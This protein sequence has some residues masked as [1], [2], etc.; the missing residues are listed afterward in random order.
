MSFTKARVEASRTCGSS[1]A[2]RSLNFNR[3][4]EYGFD[5]PV[6]KTGGCVTNDGRVAFQTVDLLP[7]NARAANVTLTNPVF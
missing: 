4:H 6:G 7:S 5:I 2:G 1:P 3:G